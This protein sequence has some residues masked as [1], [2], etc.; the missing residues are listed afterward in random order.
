LV[1]R[2]LSKVYSNFGELLE[3][4]KRSKTRVRER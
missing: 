3:H 4:K 2:S 1:I